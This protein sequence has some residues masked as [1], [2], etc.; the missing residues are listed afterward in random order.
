M[1]VTSLP[2]PCLW[3]SCCPRDVNCLYCPWIKSTAFFSISQPS[4]LPNSCSKIRYKVKILLFYS[5]SNSKRAK[6]GIINICQQMR[7]LLCS[8]PV[9]WCQG[10]AG[11]SH[12]YNLHGHGTVFW[13]SLFFHSTKSY[14][15]ESVDPLSFPKFSWKEA[16]HVR[17]LTECRK[18]S[19]L[20]SPVK[21]ANFSEPNFMS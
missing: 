17:N 14:N 6:K 9:L 12:S 3:H 7:R 4:R 11:L 10:E 21:F 1:L 19:G 13:H 5:L 20:I 16:Y 18:K 8:M 2:S 15:T